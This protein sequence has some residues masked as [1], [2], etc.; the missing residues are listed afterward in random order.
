M[1]G[2]ISII[3]KYNNVV[4]SY[5]GYTNSFSDVTDNINFLQDPNNKPLE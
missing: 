5:E 1:G 4:E 2:S 3:K